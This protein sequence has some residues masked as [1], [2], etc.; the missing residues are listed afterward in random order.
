[1]KNTERSEAEVERRGAKE[2]LM[3][4]FVM[5]TGILAVVIEG[6]AYGGDIES[7]RLI[8][9]SRTWRENLERGEGRIGKGFPKTSRS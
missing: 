5:G 1:M 9:V 7:P 4:D 8:K 2:F 3:W 6:V